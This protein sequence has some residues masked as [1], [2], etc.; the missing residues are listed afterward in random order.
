MKELVS[1]TGLSPSR[2]S[3]TVGHTVR[4][5]EPASLDLLGCFPRRRLDGCWLKEVVGSPRLN[6]IA[7]VGFRILRLGSD[8]LASRIARQVCND[9]D[10][11]RCNVAPRGK[12]GDRMV[13]RLST[14]LRTSARS[15]QTS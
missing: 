2:S 5:Y 4:G 12:T 15:T 14:P 6:R 8:L 11:T 1:A 10:E 9:L 13:P 3:S 7:G